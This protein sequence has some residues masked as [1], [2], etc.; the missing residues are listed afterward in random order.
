MQSETPKK[1]TP[2]FFSSEKRKVK[3]GGGAGNSGNQSS[4]NH[5]PVRP[6]RPGKNKLLRGNKGLPSTRTERSPTLREKA[7][8]AAGRRGK[9]HRKAW[10][11][12]DHVGKACGKDKDRQAP[13][14][15]KELPYRPSHLKEVLTYLTLERGH[16]EKKGGKLGQEDLKKAPEGEMRKTHRN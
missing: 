8:R 13:V 2:L 15:R 11:K 14:P 9:D 5:R 4:P 6:S 16:S 10:Q 12:E 7:N 3:E 1:K